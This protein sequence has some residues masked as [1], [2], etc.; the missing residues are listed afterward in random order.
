MSKPIKNLLTQ[1][2]KERFVDQD[3]VVVINFRGIGA[4]NT[5]AMRTALAEKG[6]KVTVV[7][8]T[9]ASRA[10]EDTALGPVKELLD[11]ACAF[12]YSTDPEQS[13]VVNVARHLLDQKKEMDFIEVRGAVMEGSLFLDEEQVKALS[14]YPTRE[15]A[16]SNILGALLGPAATLSKTLGDQG[17]QLA[18]A[19]A[20]PGSRLIG[21]LKAIEDK[22]GELKKSA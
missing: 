4:E 16:I 7:K 20:T 5:V 10:L 18:A 22:G 2:Y 6:V 12:V 8:N 13:S 1:D 11:G 17:G 21:A 3:G 19:V 9:L 14:K 15:E